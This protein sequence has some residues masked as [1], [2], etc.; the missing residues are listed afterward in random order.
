MHKI[1]A[2]MS[3]DEKK[4]IILEGRRAK[5]SDEAIGEGVGARKGQIVGF[6]HRHLPE[7]TGKSR[8][9]R[10]ADSSETGRESPEKARVRPAAK[11]RASAQMLDAPV[12]IPHSAWP[13][14]EAAWKGLTKPKRVGALLETDQCTWGAWQKARC[15]GKLG[16]GDLIL[17]EYHR[18]AFDI[19]SKKYTR[20]SK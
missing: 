10:T 3:F 7:L 4:G 13:P 20:S 17:C 8:G 1:W 12:L 5:K 18:R 14:A 6:R 19:F 2:K 16:E 11:K 9:A 15:F